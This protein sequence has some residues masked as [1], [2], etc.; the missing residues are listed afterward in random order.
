MSP[1]LVVL[2]FAMFAYNQIA[3]AADKLV[4]Q[5]DLESDLLSLSH[6]V[7]NF[8][9]KPT[10]NYQ[11]GSQENINIM[12]HAALKDHLAAT[13]L[14]RYEGE[15]I[16]IATEQEI[17]YVDKQTQNKMARSMWM[18][19]LNHPGLTGFLV[20]EQTENAAAVFGLV[21][22]VMANQTKQWP[23]EWQMFLSTSGDT[24]VQYA[25]GDLQAYQGGKFEEYNGL[26]TAD[27]H[28]YGKFRGKIEFVIHPR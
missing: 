13:I 15:V 20:V 1:R 10:Q 27:F 5:L 6:S 14:V 16:G 7:E 3:F 28:N 12:A 2:F 8:L 11:P 18:I 25:S 21:Q 17:L 24:L 26:N 23:D 19:Q 9:F 22:K 4:L